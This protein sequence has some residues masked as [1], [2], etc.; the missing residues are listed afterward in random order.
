MFPVITRPRFCVRARAA[1]YVTGR[2]RLL[3]GVR[4][5]RRPDGLTEDQEGRLAPQQPWSLSRR[6]SALFD[7]YLRP[8]RGCEI[9][10]GR[11]DGV[12]ELGQDEFPACGA[13][14]TEAFRERGTDSAG[15]PATA[16]SGPATWP[17][18]SPATTLSGRAAGHAAF[19]SSPPA[20]TRQCRPRRPAAA[21]PDDR[22][23][24]RLPEP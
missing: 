3:D 8:A 2:P 17:G 12:Y 24:H 15:R 10:T 4:T 22:R 19:S 1:A 18:R 13:S 7:E 20:G 11:I 14:R 23:D 5:V 21:A 9:P 16:S 6:A